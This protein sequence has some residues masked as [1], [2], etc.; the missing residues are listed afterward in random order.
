MD[1]GL[2]RLMIA[3]GAVAALPAPSPPPRPATPDASEAPG[4]NE[5]PGVTRVET[6]GEPLIARKLGPAI[7]HRL[8]AGTRALRFRTLAPE[9]DR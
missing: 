6:A 3:G 1:S 5:P 7:G 9:R 8:D 4:A 2:C